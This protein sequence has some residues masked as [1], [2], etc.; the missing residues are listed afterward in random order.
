MQQQRDKQALH[1]VQQQAHLDLA[2]QLAASPEAAAIAAAW[3]HNPAAAAAA[4]ASTGPAAFAAAG[5]LPSLAGMYAQVSF[6]WSLIH[7]LHLGIM[8]V[9]ALQMG[10]SHGAFTAAAKFW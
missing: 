4:L 10:S 5:L 8:Q 6:R 7:S 2:A 3:E 9:Q 1:A